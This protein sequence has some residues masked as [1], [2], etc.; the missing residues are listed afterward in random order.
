[1]PFVT[2]LI[3]IKQKSKLFNIQMRMLFFTAAAIAAS[4]ASLGQS[5]RLD[6]GFF[7][8]LTDDQLLNM[9]DSMFPDMTDM[10]FADMISAM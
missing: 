7:N 10:E 5:I 4:I 1:M 3:I 8:T 9:K 2:V 6:I